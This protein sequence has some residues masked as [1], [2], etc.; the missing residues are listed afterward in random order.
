[1]IKYKRW[2]SNEEMKEDL[3]NRDVWLEIYEKALPFLIHIKDEAT[4]TKYNKMLEMITKMS[5]EDYEN[6]RFNFDFL[7]CGR[8]YMG[9]EVLQL[10]IKVNEKGEPRQLI[11]HGVERR[12]RKKNITYLYIFSANY[13][14]EL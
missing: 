5:N 13:S 14:K 3:K 11:C 12:I 10:Q 8:V 6:I 1:M 4:R 9:N 7:D 2:Y